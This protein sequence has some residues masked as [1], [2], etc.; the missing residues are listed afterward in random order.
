MYKHRT[1]DSGS[2]SGSSSGVPTG[3]AGGTLA[4]LAQKKS[5]GTA[6]NSQIFISSLDPEERVD[7]SS[8]QHIEE[9]CKRLQRHTLLPNHCDAH[10]RSTRVANLPF[11][12]AQFHKT[13]PLEN[14]PAHEISSHNTRIIVEYAELDHDCA[15]LVYSSSVRVKH[16]RSASG[17]KN[18]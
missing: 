13:T 2:S 18:T 9:S 16:A 3:P 7:T 11:H 14:Y 4:W 15:E 10:N 12:M 17:C 5:H 8:I 1:T 6:H